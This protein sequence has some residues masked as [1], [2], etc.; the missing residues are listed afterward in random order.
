MYTQ[1]TA[2]HHTVEPPRL[3]AAAFC[4]IRTYPDDPGYWFKPFAHPLDMPDCAIGPYPSPMQAY[5]AACRY[6]YGPIPRDFAVGVP[7]VT[8]LEGLYDI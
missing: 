2:Y 4:R 1:V 6:A 5:L 8:G 3:P 7:A